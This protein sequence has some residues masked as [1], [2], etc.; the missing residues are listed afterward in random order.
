[1]DQRRG[2]VSF[3]FNVGVMFRIPHGDFG[4]KSEQDFCVGQ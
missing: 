3:I 4:Y 1:M 2:I